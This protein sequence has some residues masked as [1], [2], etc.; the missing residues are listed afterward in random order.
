MSVIKEP[1]GRRYIQVEAEVPGTPEEVWQAIA[2]G[3]GVTSWFVP[4][5]VA[6]GVGGTVTSTFGPGMDSVA[7]ITAWDPP[8]R[9][10]AESENMGPGSP[11][12]ATEWTVE[13]RAGGTCIVRVVHSLFA[14]TDDWDSQLGGIENGWPSFFQILRLYLT[15][16]RGLSSTT[17]QVMGS[18]PD[19][20]AEAWGRL[21]API[22]LTSIAEGQ[23]WVSPAGTPPLAGVVERISLKSDPHQVL[24][25]EQPA[26]G[27]ALFNACGMGGQVF[28]SLCFYFYGDRA[29]TAVADNQPRWQA[30]VAEHF[31]MPAASESVA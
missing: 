30:W 23:H 21:M 3:P 28:V 10:A 8:R 4:T 14:D 25:L 11:P 20:I 7:T 13:A 2:T 29:A 26:D 31:P 12:L 24:R 16:F 15:R 17:F 27:V 22:G 19:S 6:D 9:F 1:S 5:K 18:A